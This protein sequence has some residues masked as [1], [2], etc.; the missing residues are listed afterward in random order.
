MSPSFAASNNA[1]VLASPLTA[2]PTSGRKITLIKEIKLPFIFITPP[3]LIFQP[4]AICHQE[5]TPDGTTIE[6]YPN[7]LLIMHLLLSHETFMSSRTLYGCV[8]AGIKP[9]ATIT[10]GG[11]SYLL[12]LLF[13]IRR[14]L[15]TAQQYLLQDFFL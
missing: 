1:L 14:K 8:C 3:P 15:L 7:I 5:K 11:R 10:R 13:A 6:K 2:I 9:A 4:L 12:P